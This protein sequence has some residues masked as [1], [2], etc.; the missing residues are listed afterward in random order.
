MIVNEGD[1][2]TLLC[3]ADGHPKP[4]INWAR[5]DKKEFPV[6]EVRHNQ[7]RRSMGELYM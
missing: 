2:A 1:D 3:K 4:R 6:Y 7:T 5:E